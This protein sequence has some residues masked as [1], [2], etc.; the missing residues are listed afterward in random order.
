MTDT[1][2]TFAIKY[3]LSHQ[4][5][6]MIQSLLDGSLTTEQFNS[7]KYRARKANKV[8]LVLDMSQAYELYMLLKKVS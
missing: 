3:N 5:K 2:E 4:T 7:R 6:E 1:L 8:G